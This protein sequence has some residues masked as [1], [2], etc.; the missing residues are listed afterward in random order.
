MYWLI[1]CSEDGDVHVVS[2]VAETN[3]TQLLEYHGLGKYHSFKALPSEDPTTWGNHYLVI[4]GEH[5]VP[6]AVERVET[7]IKWELP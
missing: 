3:F 1:Y 2:F 5:T 4:S 7:V 6:M